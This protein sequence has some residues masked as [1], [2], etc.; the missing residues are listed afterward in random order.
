MWK[1]RRSPS[2][3]TTQRKWRSHEGKFSNSF[4][5]RQMWSE[6]ILRR[7][8]ELTGVCEVVVEFIFGRKSLLMSSLDHSES[9]VAPKMYT[10]I[11]VGL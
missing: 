7:V 4:V 1:A 9:Q 6:Q 8:H 2:M 10:S 11:I 3:S 5:H